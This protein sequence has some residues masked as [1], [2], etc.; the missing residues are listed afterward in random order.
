MDTSTH[1]GKPLKHKTHK[2]QEAEVMKLMSA[3]GH[4]GPA[5]AAA[6]RQRLLALWIRWLFAEL[7]VPLL[8]SHFYVTESEAHRQRVFYYR[9]VLPA[10]FC[11]ATLSSSHQAKLLQSSTQGP[12]CRSQMVTAQGRC[13]SILVT[14][15]ACSVGFHFT[16]VLAVSQKHLPGH[17][18]WAPV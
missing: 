4:G 3:G 13:F 5:N 1:L 12:S 15:S 10:M 8:R 2:S 14:W 9:H 6:K 18:S 16:G 17:L 11:N 7:M